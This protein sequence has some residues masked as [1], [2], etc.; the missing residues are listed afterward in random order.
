MGS[1]LTIVR[2]A[3]LTFRF[4]DCNSSASESSSLSKAESAPN[5]SEAALI[6][7]ACLGSGTCL[8]V[9]L[10]LRAFPRLLRV[11]K[12]ARATSSSVS[13]YVTLQQRRHTSDEAGVHAV[14]K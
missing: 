7:L 4:F 10:L 14:S 9:F 6:G 11:E 8:W 12:A 2:M 3:S 1:R 13:G 5:A